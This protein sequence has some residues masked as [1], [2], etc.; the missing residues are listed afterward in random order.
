MV[1]KMRQIA[2]KNGHIVIQKI[3]SQKKRGQGP[4][5]VKRISFLQ[6][7]L[8]HGTVAEKVHVEPVPI[9][10]AEAQLWVPRP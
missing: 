5:A 8:G 6:K 2:Q 7:P 9:E 1:L 4:P 10:T 3:T